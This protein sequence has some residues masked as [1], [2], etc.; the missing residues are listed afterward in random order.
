MFLIGM[1]PKSKKFLGGDP[2]S[3]LSD[4]FGYKSFRGNQFNVIEALISGHNVFSIMSTGFGK[5]LCYQIPAL[6]TPGLSIVVSPLISLMKDQVDALRAKGVR[7]GALKT[8]MEVNEKNEIHNAIKDGTLDILYVSPERLNTRSFRYLLSQSPI[9]VGL[10][11]VDEAHSVSSWGHDFRPSYLTIGSFISD[12]AESNVLALTAT[13]NPETQLNIIESLGI[14]GCKTFKSSFDRP[15]LKIVMKNRPKNRKFILNYLSEHKHESGIIF[16]PSRNRTEQITDY[17]L[18]N[19]FNAIPYHAGLREDVKK[20]NQER[21]I[22]ENPI[23]A[24][25]TIAFGMGIDKPDVRFVMHI[26]MSHSIEA[27]YQEIGRAGRDGLPAEVILYGT[28][29]DIKKTQAHLKDSLSQAIVGDLSSAN[30]MNRMAKL[31]QFHGVFESHE[32]RRTTILRSFGENIENNCGNC[33]RCLSPGPVT[34][35][36]AIGALIV[37]TISATGQIFG[38]SYIVDVL[39]GEQ[40][41]RIMS[42]E[43]NKINVFG[44][45]HDVSRERLFSICRQMLAGGYLK[46]SAIHNTVCLGEKAW[47]V[48]KNG[49]KVIVSGVPPK[50]NIHSYSKDKVQLPITLEQRMSGFLK[51]RETA[52]T[53]AGIEPNQ[54]ISDLTAERIL[55]LSPTTPQEFMSVKG[56]QTSKF[57]NNPD[58]ILSILLEPFAKSTSGDIIDNNLSEF[59]L[60]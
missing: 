2:K 1:P 27:Y 51:A 14:S 21:F 11:A 58:K 15:N 5:S 13:A 56:V 57:G 28:A 4:V 10:I 19:G 32:C 29:A 16:C 26:G 24:V 55:S 35:V 54:L 40:N 39:T 22:L 23:I 44:K 8:S 42:N 9:G 6:I 60:F 48:L 12:F 59:S 43:H 34:D 52:S 45:A 3:V 38:M 17:L 30:I 25:A 50:S 37:K 47:P 20:Q 53:I 49:K 46:Y 18:K 7:A 36:T 33:D 41:S 31:N